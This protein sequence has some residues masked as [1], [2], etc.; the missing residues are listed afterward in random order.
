MSN[1][2]TQTDAS[3][4]RD[5]SKYEQTKNTILNMYGTHT[6]LKKIIILC[7]DRDPVDAINNLEAVLKLMKMKLNEIKENA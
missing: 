6:L 2:T 4:V 5:A 7:E 1:T 3:A